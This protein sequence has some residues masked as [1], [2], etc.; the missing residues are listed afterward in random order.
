M[1]KS[2]F[3][4]GPG[5][6][7]GEVLELLVQHKYH[8]TTLIRRESLAHDFNARGVKTMLGTLDDQSTIQNQ[9]VASDI[10]IHTATARHLP[11]VE[12][13]LLGIQMRAHQKQQTIFIHT[14]GATH[15]ADN[16]AGSIAG[17]VIY[18][19]EQPEVIDA[20]PAT[21]AR[22]VDLAL[23][24]G[25]Q[26]LGAQ[27]KIAMVIPPLVYG[28]SRDKR[29][30]IQLPTLVRYALQHNY[31]GQ[32]GAGRSIWSQVHVK[33]LSRGYLTI[34]HWLE[35]TPAEQVLVNP[36]WFCENGQEESWNGWSKAI[37]QALFEAGRIRSPVPQAIPQSNYGDC[38]GSYTEVVVGSNSRNRST[39]LRKLGW[40]PVEKALVASLVEDEIPLILTEHEVRGGY[41]SII[42]H[43]KNE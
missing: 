8:V 39:R 32:V 41:P 27:A 17:Q 42:N 20:L 6:I 19:D 13:V 43:G 4:I 31:A 9:V 38:F 33:D 29:M 22:E 36:Y 24:R 12:A 14:S 18:D 3:L 15:L 28:V 11:S 5:F 35:R 1:G 37:G 23:L 7:G 34:L 21:P 25:R 10:V 40:K 16:S 2:V 30:S 26:A